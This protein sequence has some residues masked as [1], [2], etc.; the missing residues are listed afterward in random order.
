MRS[1]RSDLRTFLALPRAEAVLFV[2]ASALLP[3]V[4]LSVR[5]AG[6]ERTRRRLE[7]FAGRRAVPA[8]AGQADAQVDAAVRMVHATVRRHPVSALCLA[9]SITLWFLL[10]RRGIES[11]VVI[12]V[13]PGGA[14]LDAH[15]WVER[16]G[17]P[18]NEAQAIVDTYARLV[19]GTAA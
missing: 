6:Y 3:L 16:D 15:A 13:R 1:R 10:R 5:R 14:P 17:V 7:R 11:D 4:V 12:G 8:E 19:P 18:L 9:R 2:E